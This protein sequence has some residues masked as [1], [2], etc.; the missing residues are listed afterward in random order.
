[1]IGLD[2][3]EKLLI[4]TAIDL[5]MLLKNKHF[6]I[7]EDLQNYLDQKYSSYNKS[8]N[9]RDILQQNDKNY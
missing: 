9:K 7:N 1:M 3:V 6:D 2:A 4:K 8:Y 5:M